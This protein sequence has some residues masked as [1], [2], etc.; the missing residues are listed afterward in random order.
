MS[1][2]DLGLALLTF[3][4]V[5]LLGAGVAVAERRAGLVPRLALPVT[6]ALLAWL[7]LTALLAVSGVLVGDPGGPPRILALPLTAFATVLLLARRPTFRRLVAA[8]PPAWPIALQSFRVFV[9]LALFALYQD[10]RAP[11]QVTFEGR[12]FDIL[13]GLSAPLV[14]LALAS[15][16]RWAG[17]LAGVWNVLCAG[18]LANII[19]TAATSVPGPL[20]VDWPGG[21]FLT[22][23][24]WPVVWIPAFLAPVAV[25]LHVVW[26]TGRGARPGR[27]T[28][29]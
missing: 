19:L 7:G 16:R 9:E 11:V 14:A 10:G 17:T 4:L 26:W 12:N 1:P 22:I 28:G 21:P 2:V 20:Q 23:V 27:S 6:L 3:A 5:A 8:I 25:F 18:L 24:T 29:G 13:A 15:S